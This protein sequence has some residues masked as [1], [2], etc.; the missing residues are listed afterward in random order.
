MRTLIID[1]GDC[2]FLAERLATDGHEV[3]YFSNW[4]NADPTSRQLAPGVGLKRVERVNDPISLILDKSPDLVIF[5]HLYHDDLE[6]WVRELG[7]PVFGAGGGA[8][9]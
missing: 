7:I 4:I 6:R 3:G 8:I 1:N 5:P 2:T 9:L